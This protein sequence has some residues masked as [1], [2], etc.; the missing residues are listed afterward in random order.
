MDKATMFRFS[1]F[2]GCR[3][4]QRR[5]QQQEHRPAQQPDSGR[6]ASTALA[7]EG[8]LGGAGPPAWTANAE[9]RQSRAGTLGRRAVGAAAP[10]HNTAH[11]HHT[12][13]CDTLQV[14]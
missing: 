3:Q 5:G 1:D 9:E 8:M 11:Q 10:R 4:Q 2:G 12:M 14:D 13:V 7:M 6:Q